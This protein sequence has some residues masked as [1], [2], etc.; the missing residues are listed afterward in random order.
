LR[1]L[2][3]PPDHG[4]A[5]RPLPARHVGGSRMSSVA[6][7]QKSFA[8]AVLAPPYDRLDDAALLAHF[9]APRAADYFPVADPEET[10]PE[11]IEAVLE[12]RFELNGETHHLPAPIAWTANPSDDREWH[13]LLHKFY[14]G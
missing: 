2:R 1:A 4:G 10:R 6:A 14:Y 8:R 9:R 11:K 3:L 12:D 5:A 13:I 7:L